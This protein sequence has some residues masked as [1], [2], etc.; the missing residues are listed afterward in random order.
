MT[1]FWNR[2]FL[3]DGIRIVAEPPRADSKFAGQQK[4]FN[5]SFSKMLH[6]FIFKR[7]LLLQFLFELERERSVR[8]NRSI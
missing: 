4:N 6:V 7:L 3:L 5:R 8:Q 2:L 1:P